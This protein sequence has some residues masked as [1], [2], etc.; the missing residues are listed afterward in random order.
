VPT[1]REQGLNEVW[2]VSRG[3]AG[4]AGLPKDVEATLIAALEKAITL[5]DHR[6]KAE[7]LAL[8]PSPIKGEA[9]RKFLKDNE[10][11]TKKLMNW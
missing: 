11:A 3:I 1:F 5:P 9:Y 7:A 8:D 6:T 2:A 10:Q 4:P